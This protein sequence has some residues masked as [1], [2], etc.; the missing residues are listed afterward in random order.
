MKK[1]L[2]RFLALIACILVWLLGTFLMTVFHFSGTFPMLLLMGAIVATWKFINM[3]FI[4]TNKG[5]DSTI[6]INNS[7]SKKD[8]N[9]NQGRCKDIILPEKKTSYVVDDNGEPMLVFY[10][11]ESRL[12]VNKRKTNDSIGY[13]LNI[14]KPLLIDATNNKEIHIPNVPDDCDGIIV[15]GYGYDNSKAFIVKD[16]KSQAMEFS[17]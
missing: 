16:L 17:L 6:E 9:A 10:R 1:W 3:L 4:F 2:F 13:F 12:F 15:K 7:Q 14:R 11:S 5:E 8:V